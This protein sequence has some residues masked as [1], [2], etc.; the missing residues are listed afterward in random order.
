MAEGSQSGARNAREALV[1]ALF[2]DADKLIVRMEQVQQAIPQAINQGVQTLNAAAAA[3]QA[4]LVEAVKAE[5]ALVRQMEDATRTAY[6]GIATAAKLATEQE[7]TKVQLMLAKAVETALQK[8]S[9][10][11][12]AP[13]SWRYKVAALQAVTALLI[14]IAGGIVGATWFGHAAPTDEEKAQLAAGRD[15]MRIYPQLDQATKD[16]VERLV[17]RP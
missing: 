6:A 2:D 12:S 3:Y 9:A 13:A 7:V 11:A 5:G 14:A 16:K 17:S 10:E 15:F 8:V 4:D 1:Q